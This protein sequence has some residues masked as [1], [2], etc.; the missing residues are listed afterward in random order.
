[1]R[2]SSKRAEITALAGLLLCMVF[3][4]S[5]F[6][7]SR[8]CN[9]TAL[10]ALSW[11]ILGCLGVW[12]VLWFYFLQRRTAEQEKLDLAQI[13]TRRMS[14]TIFE[15]HQNTPELFNVAQQ[16]LKTFEKWFLPV[17]SA[18]IGLYHLGIGS[19]LLWML[20][21]QIA[22][23][24]GNL[25]VGAVLMTAVAFFSFVYALYAVGLAGEE[26]WRPLRAGGSYMLATALLAFACAITMVA[27]QYN[28]PIGLEI[29]KWLTP[30]II[31]VLGVETLL[32]VVFDFYRPR[33]SGRYSPPAFDS[34]LL[35]IISEPGPLLQKA[36]NALDYQFGFKVS[37]TWFYKI[38]EQAILPLIL[39]SVVILWLMSCFVV[40]EPGYTAIIERFG[41]AK[42]ADGRVRRLEPGLHVKMPVPFDRARVFASRQVQQIAVG[43]E[44]DEEG[45]QARPLLWKVE[46]FK[47]EYNLL[48]A[49]HSAGGEGVDSA[50]P[51]SI[52]RAAIPVHFRVKDPYAFIYNYQDSKAVLESVC[53]REIINYM[54]GS[55]IEATDTGEGLLGAGRA[56][57]AEYLR[58][59]IQQAADEKALGVEIIFLGMQ[60][61]HPAP[62]VAQAFETAIGA[63]QKKQAEILRAMAEQNSILSQTA[64]SVEQSLKLYELV[65]KFL[66]ANQSGDVDLQIR[67]GEELDEAMS[68]AHGEVYKELR[69][70]QAYA[71]EK[72]A[73]A[74]ASGERFIGQLKAWQAAGE[75]YKQHL[76]LA[77]LEEALAGIRKYIV[78]ADANDYQ[79][80]QV[81]LTEKLTPSLYD[82]DLIE[83]KK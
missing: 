14:G 31:A 7:L 21:K 17:L 5:V 57:A 70:A 44:P 15:G 19:Y 8:Y 10:Y 1:M 39:L 71:F 6:L 42:T 11:Q 51:V 83:Q 53:Y 24:P 65:G 25:L 68:R 64:G 47:K 23:E 58:Q 52:V 59:K 40:I 34:R 63:V 9:V 56:Q 12:L 38:L 3:L 46:H 13:T 79:V 78:V 66:K 26:I 16:R 35:A 61:I 67:L 28:F 48:T 45:K 29:M 18:I 43:Y 82:L 37:Q 36:A 69:L 81:D 22:V 30:A 20:Q 2:L 72:P 50:V 32:N 27:G 41:S 60:G 54:S 75:I 77:M 73:F 49:T 80:F 55:K 4:P 33:I 62:D 76:R 74:M